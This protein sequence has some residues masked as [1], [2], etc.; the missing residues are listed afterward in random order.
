MARPLE[1][2]VGRRHLD[3]LAQIHDGDA[4][5][6]VANDVEIVGDENERKPEFLAQLLEQ[7]DDLRLDRGVERGDRLIG[8]DELRPHGERPGDAYALTLPAAQRVRQAI[9]EARR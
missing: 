5:A 4:V 8:D 9:L 6:D 7:I 3:D 1:Q 2:L